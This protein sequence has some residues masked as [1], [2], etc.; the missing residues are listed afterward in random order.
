MTL[1]RIAYTLMILFLL[2]PT[3]NRSILKP[4]KSKIPSPLLICATLDNGILHVRQSYIRIHP[5]IDDRLEC[6]SRRSSICRMRVPKVSQPE[7]H[8]DL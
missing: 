5:E 3:T 2:N 8:C 1:F 6:D 4:T 7:R